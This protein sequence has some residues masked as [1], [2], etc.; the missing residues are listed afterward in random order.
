[1]AQRLN[2]SD[3]RALRV[4]AAEWD[5][6]SDD[7]FARVLDTATPLGTRVRRP[8]PKIVPITLDEATL[9]RLKRVARRKQVNVSQLAAMW[10]A[11]R[12]AHEHVEH[13]PRRMA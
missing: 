1:M 12:L 7:E 5:R 3:R 6:L 13:R 10:I 9:N 8:R 4:E 2:P 11:E